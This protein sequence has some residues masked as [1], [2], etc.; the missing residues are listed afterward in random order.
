VLG[1]PPAAAMARV[2]AGVAPLRSY[3]RHV[4]NAFRVAE[5]LRFYDH[6]GF[7]AEQIR[8]ALVHDI[9]ERAFA[10]GASTISQQVVKNLFLTHERTLARKLQE[11]VLTWRMEQVIPKRRILEAYLDLVELGPG[12]RG[13]EAASR[14]YF[15]R[16]ARELTPLQAVHLAA[17]A[18]APVALSGQL[19][20]GVTRQW[21]TRLDE[22]LDFMRH[23][24]LLS[25]SDWLRARAER[26]RL[27]GDSPTPRLARR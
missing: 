2:G 26:L 13:V 14:A 20:G 11:A 7:D 24:R 12:L 21:R 9:A 8:R 23:E 3:G 15:G 22:L 1:D 16:P 10:R 4:P 18:P 5:D 19:A 6:D 25:P 27:A 17:L